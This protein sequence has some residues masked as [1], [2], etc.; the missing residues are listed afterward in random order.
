MKRTLAAAFS[1]VYFICWSQ[2]AVLDY[3]NIS[4]VI[5]VPT[6]VRSLIHIF[7]FSYETFFE[8]SIIVR[9]CAV[10]SPRRMASDSAF[11][12]WCLHCFGLV[13]NE[14]FY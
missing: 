13:I 5:D 12:C 1:L 2:G 9:I 8:F 10:Q 14:I 6:I 7:A 3:T 11:R 4:D